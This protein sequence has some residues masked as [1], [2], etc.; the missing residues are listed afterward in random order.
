MCNLGLT[1]RAILK[2]LD[3]VCL[4]GAAA[5]AIGCGV[6]AV[7]LIIEVITT[8]FLSYSQPWVV[9]YSGYLLAATLFAGAGWT[10]GQGGHIRVNLVLQWLS[11]RIF[12]SVD[13]VVT[14]FALGVAAYVTMAVVENAMRSFELGSV[15]Y[16]PSR[17]PIWIPQSVLAFGWVV[18]CLGLAGRL[19]RLIIGEPAELSEESQAT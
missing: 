17:T 3:A 9:E 5:A 18:L 11:P 7:M 15:S 14:V 8:S 19:L 13:L 10:L 1:M 6:M 12:R 4:F 16:Y 2:T